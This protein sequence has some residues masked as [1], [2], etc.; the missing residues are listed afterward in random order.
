MVIQKHLAAEII[1]EGEVVAP[2]IVG[3]VDV[4]VAIN[5][6]RAQAVAVSLSYPELKLI[7]IGVA[8]GELDFPYI[9]GLLS[10]RETKLILSAWEKLK[11]VP[12]ILFVDGQGIAHPRRLGI[13][14]HLGL[15]LDVP[16]I[17][18]A[19]SRL[20][21]DYIEPGPHLGDATPLYD[22]DE[23]VGVTLRTKEGSRPLFISVG[24]RLGV[25]N[26][27]DWVLRCLRGYRIPEPTRLAHL[28]S[29]NKLSEQ[30]VA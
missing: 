14:S 15:W 11:S 7:Q 27:M 18:C 20:C 4:S 24:H 29:K 6:R 3:G 10:F 19:K 26:A 30:L 8:E 25:E 2:N 9:P 21:G 5:R 22:R 16:T 17:G 1:K 28:A 23:Q 13:A 12:E